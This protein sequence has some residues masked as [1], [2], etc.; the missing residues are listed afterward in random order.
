MRNYFTLDGV[1]ST[2]FGVYISGQGT[3]SSPERDYEM[4]T[5]PGRNGDLVG[6]ETRFMNGIL[7]YKAGIYINFQSQ[8]EALRA[9]L[10]SLYGYKRLTDTY[11]PNEFRQ[12]I[13]RGPFNPKVLPKNDAGQFEIEFECKPQRFLTSGETAVTKTASGTITNP[14]RFASRPLLVVTG[15][16][17]LGVGSDTI[18]ITAASG[19]TYIDCDMQDAYNANGSR[20]QYVQLSGYEFP[21]LKPGSNGITLGTGI[22]KVVITPRWFTI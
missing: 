12:V 6:T 4:I 18:T 17:Q 14:T 15:T 8:I 20:N 9:F 19:D 7:T 2:F 22:T 11:H 16:G 13:F 21:T 3:F 1:A 10:N 5:V